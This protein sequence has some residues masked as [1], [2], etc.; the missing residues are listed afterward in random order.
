MS[1]LTGSNG[2]TT[3]GNIGVLVL[4]D[5][6]VTLALKDFHTDAPQANLQV[7][8]TIN[9]KLEKRKLDLGPLPQM[10]GD[11]H[12]ALPAGT[13]VSLFNTL[14]ILDVESNQT[15]GQAAIA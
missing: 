15:V 1:T 10:E 3:T 6:G 5:G 4:G 2:H 13:D 7:Y 9:G 12:L 8:L 14:V 11:F